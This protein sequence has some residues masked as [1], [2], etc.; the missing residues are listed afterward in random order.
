MYHKDR[1]LKD[2]P[3]LLALGEF[4]I[5]K[6]LYGQPITYDDNVQYKGVTQRRNFTLRSIIWQKNW[7]ISTSYFDRRSFLGLRPLIL[8]F[9]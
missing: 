3:P 2:V 4:H 9:N 8:M 6:L 7:Y 1:P 5:L